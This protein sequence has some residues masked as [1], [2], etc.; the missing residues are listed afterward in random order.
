MT[1]PDR[2]LVARART[3][4]AVVA[5]LAAQIEADR[6]LPDAAVK[7]LI[8]AG[9]YKLFTP[10]ALGGA[11]A[12]LDVAALAL[13][14]IA[15]ADGSAGWCAMIGATASLVSIYLGDAEAREI[16]GPADAVACGVFAPTGRATPAEGGYRVTGR[17]AFASG[18]QNAGWRMGGTV[19][20]GDAPLPSG[21]PNVRCMMFRA[22]ETGIHDTWHT[23]G[24]RGTGS[25]DL[26]VSDVFVP[27]GRAFSMITDKPRH[28]GP[29]YA[30]SPFGVLATCIAS[31]AIGIARGAADAFLELATAKQPLGSKRTIAHRELVQL[32]VAKTEA[33]IRG[34][35]ALLQDAVGEAL[36]EPSLRSR[37]Q[38]RAAAAYATAQAAAAV[39][40][41]YE[42]GGATSIYTK[43]P[44]QRHFRD[45]HVATQHVMVGPVA[46]TM[47]GRV[48]LGLESDA[49]LL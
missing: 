46:S 8:E 23:S 36:R 43:N 16:F 34:A 29:T 31:V 28:E 10:R 9:V 35:R 20:A 47:A 48:L 45:V 42:A 26:E 18:C 24:L 32:G 25:H 37:A 3:A 39:D 6:R 38:L 1:V 41:A 40:L 44:L 21:A 33:T 15:R 17:W 22:S 2:D 12:S 30:I 14:E 49:S 4:A 27:S 19:V 5:P 7:A 13:E 11:E